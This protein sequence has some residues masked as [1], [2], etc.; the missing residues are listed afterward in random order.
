MSFKDG[1]PLDIRWE[2]LVIIGKKRVTGDDDESCLR[3]KERD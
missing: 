1:I 2:D 3:T